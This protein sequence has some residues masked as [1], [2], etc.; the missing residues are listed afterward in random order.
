[1]GPGGE[2]PLPLTELSCF[3]NNKQ[4]RRSVGKP[5]EGLRKPY[6]EKKKGVIGGG[7]GKES[8]G[9][10]GKIEA[11]VHIHG[12]TFQKHS[13]PPFPRVQAPRKDEI[14]SVIFFTASFK[15][16]ENMYVVNVIVVAA[17]MFRASYLSFLETVGE[18][19]SIDFLGL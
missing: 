15:G 5:L 14:S 18:S 11:N 4:R 1:M 12:R 16:N 8:P 13:P 17:A 3:L 6:R 2:V 9:S 7:G 10:N 19:P